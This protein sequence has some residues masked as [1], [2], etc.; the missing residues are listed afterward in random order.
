MKNVV[1][2]DVEGVVLV[3]TDVSEECQFLIEPH[4]VTSLM[5]DF[6]MIKPYK[7]P[8]DLSATIE[9]NVPRTRD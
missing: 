9:M 3:I 4:G 8:S 1:S 5:R 6:F 7:L 2:W